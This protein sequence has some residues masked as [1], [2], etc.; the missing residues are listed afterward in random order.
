MNILTQFVVRTLCIFL[1]SWGLIFQHYATASVDFRILKNAW[2]I[3]CLLGCKK[4][5]KKKPSSLMWPRVWAVNVSR[6]TVIFHNTVETHC[7]LRCVIWTVSQRKDPLF[8]RLSSTTPRTSWADGIVASY[9]RGIVN[10]LFYWVSFP[11]SILVVHYH[12]YT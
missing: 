4:K 7:I 1:K 3:C 8:L 2:I 9:N 12:T 6:E 11:S 10:I 5:P